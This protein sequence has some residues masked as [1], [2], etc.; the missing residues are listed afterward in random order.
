MFKEK[1][2]CNEMFVPCTPL[3]CT[4]CYSHYLHISHYHHCFLYSIDDDDSVGKCCRWCVVSILFLFL[5]VWLICGE[6]L[7]F[8]K[9]VNFVCRMTILLNLAVLLEIFVNQLLRF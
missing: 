3:H 6:Y 2:L 5:F 1:M 7:L 4:L 8:I 9:L